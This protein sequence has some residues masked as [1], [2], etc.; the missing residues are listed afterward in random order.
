MRSDGLDPHT[1]ECHHQCLQKT[2]LKAVGDIDIENLKKTD[3]VKIKE[4]GRG[5]GSTGDR[6][7]ILTFRKLLGFIVDDGHRLNF[8][9]RNIDI[10]QI[11][12]KEVVALDRAD[13]QM[14]RDELTEN[15]NAYWMKRRFFS[16]LRT[17]A[18]VE[19]ALHTGLRLS[20]CIG[21]NINDIDWK[22]EEIDY[23]N[24]KTGKKRT[25]SIVGA[26]QYIRE[27]LAARTDQCPAL[28]VASGPFGRPAKNADRMKEDGVKS[29]FRELK[30]RLKKRGLRKSFHFHMLRKTYVTFLLE[31]KVDLKSV[32]YQADHQSERTTLRYYAAVNA[33]HSQKENDRVMKDI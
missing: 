32:Q 4:L 6:R 25:K 8:D 30:I 22:R 13:V 9:W 28:F 21:I 5:Q 23:T 31:G 16:N 2:V 33:K 7:A 3:S 18:I 26:T 15:H 1:I 27:Y 20:E 24:I 11:L 17:R 10:P 12:L 29:C 14:I 19:L